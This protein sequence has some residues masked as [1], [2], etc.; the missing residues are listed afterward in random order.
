MCFGWV[1]SKPNKREDESFYQYFSKRNPK[2]NWSRIN[3]NKIE[4]LLKAGKIEKVG[5]KMIEVAKKTEKWN[6]LDDVGNLILPKEMK[7]IFEKKESKTA[8]ENL[9][10]FSR[11]AKRGILEW[12]FNAK[13]LPAKLKRIK[14]TVQAAKE[15]KR[16]E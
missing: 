4:R 10:N 7:E 5:V 9:E 16:I 8:K 11:S 13:T 2:S 12:V 1:D 15:N 14:E 3:K 6:A